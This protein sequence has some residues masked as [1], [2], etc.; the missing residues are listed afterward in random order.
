MTVLQITATL[1]DN[2]NTQRTAR[3]GS[4]PS[5]SG[6]QAGPSMDLRACVR[7]RFSVSPGLSRLSHTHLVARAAL[8][9][10]VL[11]LSH[12]FFLSHSFPLICFTHPFSHSALCLIHDLISLSLK[13]VWSLSL[14]FT[15]S[16][17]SPLSHV[18]PLTRSLSHTQT[19]H[20]TLPLLLVLLHLPR[21]LWL[22]HPLCFC[23][24]CVCVSVCLSACVSVCLSVCLSVCSVTLS[25]CHSVTLSLC[26]P[27]CQ[28]VCLS[29][30]PSPSLS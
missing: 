9:L 11:S 20:S 1:G 14:V 30:S 27:V 25:L 8:S 6:G 2:D 19:D 18:L 23:S 5:L 24:L 16:L 22:S 21:H 4:P 10:E 17:S 29:G 28:S 12:W 13:L 3:A 26:L 7:S 15:C